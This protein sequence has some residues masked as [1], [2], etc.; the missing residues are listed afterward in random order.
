MKLTI[1]QLK[2]PW[3]NGAKVGDVIELAEQPAWAVGKC[4]IA[5]DD[6]E[7]TLASEVIGDG[8]GAAL[9]EIDSINAQVEDLAKKLDQANA[10]VHDAI[11]ALNAAED[12]ANAAESKVVELEASRDYLISKHSGAAELLAAA[13]TRAESAEA[14]VADLTAKLAATKATKK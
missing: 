14:Q 1:T 3:P 5:D 6:A 12:R 2:A 10:Q 9:P 7:V 8:A 11:N 13:E 4:S